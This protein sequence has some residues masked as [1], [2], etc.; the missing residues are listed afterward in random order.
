MQ[1][2]VSLLCVLREVDHMA[3]VICGRL[4]LGQV[5]SGRVLRLRR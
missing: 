2:W 3:V 4:M 5:L 1:V